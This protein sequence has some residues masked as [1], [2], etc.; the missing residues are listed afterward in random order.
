MTDESRPLPCKHCGLR[1]V[2]LRVTNGP[3][4]G[5]KQLVGKIY[6][7][8]IDACIAP[9]VQAMNAAGIPTSESCCGHG[10]EKGVIFLQDGRTLCI[11]EP[12]EQ[13]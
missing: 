13:T 2:Y 12:H 9:I 10:T 4:R 3:T 7:A 11:E 6:V 1:K 8:E 5:T